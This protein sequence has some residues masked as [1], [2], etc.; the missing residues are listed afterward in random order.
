MLF[1]LRNI[2]QIALVKTLT[3]RGIGLNVIR[4]FIEQAILRLFPSGGLIV[5]ILIITPQGWSVRNRARPWV[6]DE[7]MPEDIMQEIGKQISK[8]DN[9]VVVNLSKIKDQVMREL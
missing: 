6:P 2:F 9:V 3:E 1:S 4:N 5:E 7:G 8:A